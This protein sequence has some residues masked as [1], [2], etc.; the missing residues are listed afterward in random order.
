MAGSQRSRVILLRLPMHPHPRAERSSTA[1]G[2]TVRRYTSTGALDTG[3]GNDGEA[4]ILQPDNGSL[5]AVIID[6]T[7]RIVVA[8]NVTPMT[9]DVV[10]ARL[11]TE[12][13]LDGSFGT[14]GLV[15]V[16]VQSASSIEQ[17]TKVALQSDGK[18]LVCARYQVPSGFGSAVVRLTSSGAV[19]T[20][21]GVGG[22]VDMPQLE[23]SIAVQSDDRIVVA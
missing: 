8:G 9:P 11:V 12:G 13:T 21:F 14:G 22:K 23:A 20:S 15:T 16:D 7:G 6:G 2:S 5:A 1:G 18:I 4:T 17:V 3:F 10:V 19:D